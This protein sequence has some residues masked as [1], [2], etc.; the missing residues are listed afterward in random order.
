MRTRVFD[1]ADVVRLEQVRDEI[2]AVDDRQSRL[3]AHRNRRKL[4]EL[5]AEQAALLERLGFDTY[6]SYVMGIPSVRAELERSS[7]LDAATTR[8]EHIERELQSLA[9]E[10][11]DPRELRRAEI[12]LERLLAGA[13]E[14]LGHVPAPGASPGP[15]ASPAPGASPP[16]VTTG[17]RVHDTIT[18]L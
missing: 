16:E 4:Q 7:R 11:P 3:A 12:E 2:F 14:L 8:I 10:E 13:D 1:Q 6:S 5:R 15:A 18:A 17:D 9:A